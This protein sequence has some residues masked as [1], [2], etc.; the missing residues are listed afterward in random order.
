L[1]Q[2]LKSLETSQAQA[3][4]MPDVTA[5]LKKIVETITF[6]NGKEFAGHEVLAK[7][8]PSKHLFC[9]TL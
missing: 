4:K 9:K 2:L 6:D 1:E 7:K 8:N 3:Q 5:I